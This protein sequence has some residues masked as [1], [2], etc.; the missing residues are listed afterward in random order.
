MTK[1]VFGELVAQ[2][3]QSLEKHTNGELIVAIG[4]AQNQIAMARKWPLVDILNSY[5]EYVTPFLHQAVL[6]EEVYQ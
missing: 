5:V 2:I 3:E 4:R 6:T 1:K